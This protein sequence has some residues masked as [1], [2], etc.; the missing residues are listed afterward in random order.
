MDKVGSDY[1]G[2]ANKQRYLTRFSHKSEIINSFWATSD[3][4]KVVFTEYWF[5]DSIH[6]SEENLISKKIIQ[7]WDD[8]IHWIGANNNR[9]ERR[10]QESFR[11]HLQVKCWLPDMGYESRWCEDVET[12]SIMLPLIE[13]E[14]FYRKM[15]VV[16]G[17]V[18]FVVTKRLQN[19]NI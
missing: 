8:K 15:S 10:I 5:D 4:M 17:R 1:E 14:K 18:E 9:V 6:C 16:K 11:Q 12:R 3:M 19:W 13:T 7:A 2:T